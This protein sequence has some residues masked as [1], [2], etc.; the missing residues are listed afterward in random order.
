MF[1]MKNFVIQVA[2]NNCTFHVQDIDLVEREW[3]VPHLCRHHTLHLHEKNPP[4]REMIPDGMVF[5][6][7]SLPR[8][9]SICGRDTWSFLVAEV[10]IDGRTPTLPV[11]SFIPTCHPV[12]TK[13]HL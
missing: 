5:S 11:C 1:V 13:C 3:V 2:T 7:G 12:R 4:V 9:P 8:P 10:W 6:F